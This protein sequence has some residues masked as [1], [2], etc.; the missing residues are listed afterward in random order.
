MSTEMCATCV[1][2]TKTRRYCAPGRCY[3]GH[4][5]CPAFATWVDLRAQPY[6]DAETKSNSHHAKSWASREGASWIDQL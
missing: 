1:E 6:R 2:T 3:C 4:E 5:A